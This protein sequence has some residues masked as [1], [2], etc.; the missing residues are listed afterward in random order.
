MSERVREPKKAHRPRHG[1][2]SFYYR[3]RDGRWVGTLEAGWNP[4]GSRRRIAVGDRDEDA[5]WDKYQAKRKLLITKGRAAALQRSITVSAWMNKWLKIQA[6]RLRPNSYNGAAS[7]VRR[8]I[9]PTIG[10]RKLE[11]LTANDVRSVARAVIDAGRSSTTAGTIQGVLQKALRDAIADG[12]TVPEPPLLAGKPAKDRSNRRLVIPTAEAIELVRLA[13]SRTDGSRWLAALTQGIRQGERLGLRWDDVDF[14]AKSIRISWQLQELVL[15]RE[16]GR[17]R[18]PD[19]YEAERLEGRWHLVRPKSGSSE[20]EI[21]LLP[22]MEFALKQWAKVAPKSAHGLVWAADG[23]GLITDKTDTADWQAFL[24]A[25]GVARKS[26]KPYDLHSARHTTATVL[27]EVRTDPDVIRAIM[28]HSD[29]VT[30]AG[31]KHVSAELMRQALSAA[32]DVLQIS[33]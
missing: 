18:V 7:Y 3:E 30:T 17:Y 23:G 24:A 20:R 31:Y 28:G 26:G 29:I 27:M 5:A 33:S 13:G 4:S 10:S 19:G 16:T 11:E 1:E 9:V 2:G 12:Y 8:W 14:E 21:P 15:D 32:A 6:T 25:A 22:W